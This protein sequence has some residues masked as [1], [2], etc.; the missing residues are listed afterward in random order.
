MTE[1]NFLTIGIGRVGPAGLH[2]MDVPTIDG[3]QLST[4]LLGIVAW[5]DFGWD[6][7]SEVGV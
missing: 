7:L 2:D 1:W 6:A 5:P 3:P 4:Q